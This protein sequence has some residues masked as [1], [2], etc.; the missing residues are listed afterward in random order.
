MTKK[1][2]AGNLSFDT[3]DDSLRTYF[4][5]VGSVDSAQVIVDRETGRSRGFGFVE[6]SSDD[7][8]RQ[9]VEKL[10]GTSLDGRSIRVSEAREKPERR[11]G[12]Y[13]GGG[14]GGGRRGGGGGGRW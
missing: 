4:E 7:E 6:M 10:D 5:T 2:Y 11:R 14:G 12:G 13:E 1:L 3:R 8:A 9:A